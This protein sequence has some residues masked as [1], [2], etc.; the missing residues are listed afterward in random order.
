MYLLA[1][2]WWGVLWAWCH[3][4]RMQDSSAQ[5]L[6]KH[7]RA[8]SNA[9]IYPLLLHQHCVPW[10]GNEQ[11]PLTLRKSA[12]VMLPPARP[13][14][15]GITMH[16]FSCSV[17]LQREGGLQHPTEGCCPTILV[18]GRLRPVG[19]AAC[20]SLPLATPTNL[21][22]C[23]CTPILSHTPRTNAHQPNCYMIKSGCT[24]NLS[25]CAQQ[26]LC[27]CVVGCCVKQM[28]G[29]AHLLGTKSVTRHAA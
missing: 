22:H 28:A 5:V 17:C 23:L 7:C 16:M 14:A 15:A 13:P 8:S 6:H 2:D 10:W 25:R 9:M 20:L 29:D 21:V 24:L 27:I 3:D 1:Y 11:L 4:E 19:S 18:P 26:Q 12:A